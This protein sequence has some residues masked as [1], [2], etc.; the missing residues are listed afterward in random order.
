MSLT[1]HCLEC[2]LHALRRT[3]HHTVAQRALST[4]I[5]STME[6]GCSP[7]VLEQIRF[8]PCHLLDERARS[9]GRNLEDWLPAQAEVVQKSQG[10]R[11]PAYCRKGSFL[12]SLHCDLLAERRSEPGAP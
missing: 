5:S 7:G 10:K 6:N 9:D 11:R 4:P 12:A 8:R 2:I 1:V 3:G